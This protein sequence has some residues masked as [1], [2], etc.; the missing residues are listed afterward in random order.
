LQLTEQLKAKEAAWLVDTQL[1]SA[2]EAALRDELA[3]LKAKA[4]AAAAA[5]AAVVVEPPPSQD[6]DQLPFADAAMEPDRQV[7]AACTRHRVREDS[8]TPAA[9]A[10]SPEHCGGKMS[11]GGC[12]NVS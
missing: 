1:A 5:A 4:A 8:E 10:P 3:A 12:Q 6:D 7:R 11:K 9:I 2:R